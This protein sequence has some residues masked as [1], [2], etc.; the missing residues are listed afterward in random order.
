VTGDAVE[1]VAGRGWASV[2]VE[3]RRWVLLNALAVTALLN[4]IINAAIAW[5]S[6]I[7]YPTVRPWSVPL[8]G[9]P[10]TFGGL[11][12]VL[13]VLPIVTSVVCTLSIRAFQSAGLPVLQPDEV[14]TRVGVFVVGP[15]RRGLRLAALS[16][17]IFGPLDVLVGVLAL[18]H[19][20]SRVDYVCTQTAAGIV[21]GA[22]ITPVVALAAMAEPARTA[23][24][25]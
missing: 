1:Q 5:A 17:V 7:G 23:R 10:S 24:A 22:L 18:D 12:S 13:V 16:V 20:V 3:H 14:P 11:I 25:A 19:D 8:I 21:L 4:L 15:I 9:G 2:P 6:S